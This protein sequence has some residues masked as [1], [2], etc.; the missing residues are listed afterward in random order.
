[1]CKVDTCKWRTTCY[2]GSQTNAHITWRKMKSSD[3][4]YEVLNEPCVFTT[5][6]R[7]WCFYTLV[8]KAFCLALSASIFSWSNLEK[9]CC[10]VRK[11][12]NPLKY[13]Q[14]HMF[15]SQRHRIAW[16]P[17]V[18]VLRVMNLLAI[19]DSL[20]GKYL[21]LLVGHIASCPWIV[22]QVITVLVTTK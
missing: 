7:L 14:L 10:C 21:F 17:A 19:V 8:T 3:E 2:K 1:M 20:P 4:S 11:K 12:K 16:R 18:P 15:Q 13:Y 5:L 22:L 6:V 9:G